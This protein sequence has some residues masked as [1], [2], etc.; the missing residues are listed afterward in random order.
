MN[1]IAKLDAFDD[2]V[3]ELK[4][5]QYT[6]YDKET[7][8]DYVYKWSSMLKYGKDLGFLAEGKK[9]VELGGGLSPVQFMFANKGCQVINLDLNFNASWFQTHNK[10]YKHATPQFIEESEKNLKNIQFIAGNIHDTI[11]SIPSNSIDAAVDTCALH[12]FIGDGNNNL[13]NEIHR[14]LKPNGYF[15]SIGDIANP[16]LGKSDIEFKF[17]K[18]MAF[19]LSKNPGLTLV[20]PYDYDTWDEYTK[21]R[22]N[23]ITRTCYNP[24]QLSLKNMLYDPKSIPY[25][26]IPIL[27]IYIWTAT[28]ILQKTS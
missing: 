21:N 22:Q 3:D 5:I 14:I 9:I 8:L 19:V 26:N 2:L 16:H 17:P 18:D 7:N 10:Y 24:K 28:Y 4:Y 12:V 15:V 6:G 11:K 27:P 23:A 1:S 13:I 20:E 25:N